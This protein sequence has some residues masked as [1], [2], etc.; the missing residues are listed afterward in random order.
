LTKNNNGAGLTGVAPYGVSS[1]ERSDDSRQ[2]W[3]EFHQ[4]MEESLNFNQ[5]A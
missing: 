4:E 3:W 1:E 2:L 5:K